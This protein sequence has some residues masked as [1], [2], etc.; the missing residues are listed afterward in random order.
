M[1]HMYTHINITIIKQ[2]K[3]KDKENRYS[4]KGQI[5]RDEEKEKADK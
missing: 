4:S 2:I 5:A 3:V 1:F